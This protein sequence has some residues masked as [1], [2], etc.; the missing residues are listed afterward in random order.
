[1]KTRRHIY[2]SGRVQGVGFRYRARYIADS[3]ELTGW[4]KNLWDGRVEME[5]QGE[6]HEIDVFLS[7]LHCQQ[8]IMITELEQETI[9]VREDENRFTVRGY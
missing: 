6:A 8:F 9:P 5:V 3:L 2:V 1:M 7:R 4:V